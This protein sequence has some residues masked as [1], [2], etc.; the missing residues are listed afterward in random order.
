MKDF[1]FWS[2]SLSLQY[3][4]F[5]G[6]LL[7]LEKRNVCKRKRNWWQKV[8]VNI[9][10]VHV[11]LMI[12]TKR[13]VSVMVLLREFFQSSLCHCKRFTTWISR[14][15]SQL[16]FHETIQPFINISEKSKLPK[17]KD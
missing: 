13:D 11:E 2:R 1:V 6:P 5:C 7:V 17:W 16:G 4:N 15:N 9:E 8:L 3:D 12:W 14:N 10:L